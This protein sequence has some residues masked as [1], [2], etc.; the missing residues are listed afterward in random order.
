[1]NEGAITFVSSSVVGSIA[2]EEHPY[3]AHGLWLQ[4]LLMDDF[5]TRML[6]DMSEL[7]EPDSVGSIACLKLA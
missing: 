2:D 4:V 6:T 7:E 5:I 3:A 1:M